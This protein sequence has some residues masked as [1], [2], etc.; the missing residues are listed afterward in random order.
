M[1]GI[2]QGRL[3]IHI[4]CALSVFAVINC[5]A[6]PQD[7]DSIYNLSLEELSQLTIKVATGSSVPIEKAPAIASVITAEEMIAMGARTLYEALEYVPGVHIT[8]SSTSRLDPIIS[9]RGIHT[10]LNNQV[11][12]LLNGVPLSNISQNRPINFNFPVTNISRIEVIRG[13]GSAIFGADAYAGV[14]NI[15]TKQPEEI[16]QVEIGARIGSFDSTDLWL[17][18]KFQAE[19]WNIGFGF[20]YFDTTGD[21]SRKIQQDQQTFFDSQFNTNASLAPGQIN[22]GHEVF[23]TYLAINNKNFNLRL[24]NWQATTQLG[25]GLS[26]ALDPT[27][28]DKSNLFVLDTDYTLTNLKD[29]EII[30]EGSYFNYNFDAKLNL[31][32]PGTTIP[33]GADGNV[34]TTPSLGEIMFS[35]G[36]IGNPSTTTEKSEL[37][38]TSI[39]Q[40]FKNHRLRY[41]LG[42]VEQSADT[43]ESKN[44]GPGVITEFAPTIDGSL[45]NV[46]DTENVFLPDT[47]RNLI[48]FSF[49]DEWD[50]TQNWNF[51]G[52]IRYDNYSD[53]GDTINPRLALV[54]EANNE[55]T[56]KILYG[57]AFRVPTFTELGFRNNPISLG[58]E[59]LSPEKIE[60]IELS[61][62]YQPFSDFLTRL[63]LFDYSARDLI[64]FVP[65]Q[66]TGTSTAD[67]AFDQDGYGLEWEFNWQVK[68]QFRLTGNYSFQDSEDSNTG[69]TIPDAPGSQAS[70]IA[71][72]SINQKWKLNSQF[73]YVTDRERLA[74]DT[75]DTIN[76]YYL[77]NLVL[78]RT[79]LAKHFDITLAIKN[80]TDEDAREPSNG[81]IID[82]IPLEERSYWLRIN[83]AIK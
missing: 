15:I 67:N 82:D 13:P 48:Y 54:W 69:E 22:T 25:T 77:L 71:N 74:L 58:N 63:S 61:F 64:V 66:N 26:Q 31:L 19:D 70:L 43:A 79:K 49:Q 44:F 46:S 41:S 45:T 47:S 40:G 9:I 75:R 36:L 56:T 72:W 14:V 73:N 53:F 83:Y 62:S 2:T 51:V 17:T 8:P 57:Q 27:G 11:L 59:N 60:T 78:H 81:I 52:G 42:Y 12:V 35:D 76:D 23:D 80:L 30:F 24:W 5:R 28:K 4:T 29:W 1:A 65:D 20:T 39:Y 33:I 10:D 50:F 7:I 16:D 32:P 38:I 3:K 37:G 55:L 18:S 68:S 34:G 21:N 6:E